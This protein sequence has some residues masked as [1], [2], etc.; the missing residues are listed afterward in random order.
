MMDCLPCGTPRVRYRETGYKLVTEATRL[1]NSKIGIKFG[2]FL[3]HTLK[4]T[5]HHLGNSSREIVLGSR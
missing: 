2:R 4:T 5:V 1:A 3:E